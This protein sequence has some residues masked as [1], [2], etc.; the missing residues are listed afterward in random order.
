[1]QFAGA[2]NL[3]LHPVGKRVDARNANAVQTAGNLVVRAVELS[4][5]VQN[6]KHHFDRGF[7]LRRVH[8]NRDASPVVAHGKRT[9]LVDDNINHRAMPG[10]SLVNRVVHHLIH[11]MMVSAFAGIADI[12]GRALAH[13]L[14]SLK[15]LNVFGVVIALF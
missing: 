8:I 15:N 3:H 10:K 1:M 13:G 2:L 12:H 11:E 9:V 4:A 7:T 6:G 14:H 5:G